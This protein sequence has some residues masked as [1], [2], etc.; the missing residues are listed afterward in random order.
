MNHLGDNIAAAVL[1]LGLPTTSIG[2]FI[3]ALT[4]HNDLALYKIPGVTP[5]IVKA[6]SD[7]LLMTYSTGFKHVW[8]AASC[9]VAIAAVGKWT[10]CVS[11][12]S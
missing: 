6:G 9:F 5:Q 10:F 2:P 12:G 8:I 7:A 11:A 1:P 4:M 3:G